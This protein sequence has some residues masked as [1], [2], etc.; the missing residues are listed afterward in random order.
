MKILILGAALLAVLAAIG[1]V[2]AVRL[3]SRRTRTSG[4]VVFVSGPLQGDVVELVPGRTRIGALDDNDITIP[5]KQVSRY[6][7]ELRVRDGRVHIWDLES[8]NNTFVNGD[9]VDNSELRPGDVIAIGDAE[10]RY[11]V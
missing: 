10:M 4:R 7:A 6:H 2:I 5:S 3:Y 11:E 9:R 8:A 1:V